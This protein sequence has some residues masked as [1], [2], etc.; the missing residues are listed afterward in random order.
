MRREKKQ[1]VPPATHISRPNSNYRIA[2]ST[3]S[4]FKPKRPPGR[5]FKMP[6]RSTTAPPVPSPATPNLESTPAPRRLSML[7]SL[8]VEILEQIFLKSLNLNLPRAS[9]VIAAAV[10]REKIY[11]ILIILALWD[12]NSTNPDSEPIKRILRPL[13]Y[14]P[15]EL[16]ERGMLQQ[17]VLRTRWCTMERVREQIPTLMILTIHRLWIN[18]GMTMELDQQAALEKF[19]NRQDDTIREFSGEG[20]PLELAPDRYHSSQAGRGALTPA[21]HQYKLRVQPMVKIEIRSETM[22]YTVTRPALSIIKFPDH[23][24]RGRSTGFT[25]NDVMYLEMLRMCSNNYA[26]TGTP[27]PLTNSWVR[28][29]VLHEGVDK[30]LR[31]HNYNALISLLKLDEYFYRFHV[32]REG[33]PKCYMFPSDHFITVTQVGRFRPDRPDRHHL[34][35]AF[36]EALIRASAESLPTRGPEILQWAHENM[37]LAQRGPTPYNNINGRLA[38]WVVN[39]ML[40][41]PEQKDYVETFPQGQLFNCGQLDT[42][43]V[44][45]CRFIEQVLA[46]QRAPLKNWLVESQFHV[47][48]WW[49]EE[50]D[51]LKK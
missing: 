19:M 14:V 28:R 5:P 31:T 47:D 33:R 36:F 37:R 45:A 17:E 34:N 15:L 9:P 3:R 22:N 42:T 18:H 12:D 11:K 2:K 40:R 13:K 8:P 38:T 39:F 29:S 51:S 24:L 16:P 4:P 46:P 44:E 41:L 25:P 1:R 35:A 6:V 7:E 49:V 27:S 30:A 50:S 23:L 48:N 26:Q 10:S 32:S 21:P 20:P 43:D